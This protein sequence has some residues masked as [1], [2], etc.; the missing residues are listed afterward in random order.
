MTTDPPKVNSKG[1]YNVSQTAKLLG[2]DR[3]TVYRYTES[4]DLQSVR[5]ACTS[6][7]RSY[8]GSEIL[9]F[10]GAQYV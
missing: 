4:G 9:R 10:W 1:M 7:R 3:K 8:L 6:G 2:I 5:R